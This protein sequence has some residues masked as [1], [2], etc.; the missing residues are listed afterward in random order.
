MVAA[1]SWL[2]AYEQPVDTE[3]Y[4]KVIDRPMTIRE[5]MDFYALFE[6]RYLPLPWPEFNRSA[7]EYF[8]RRVNLMRKSKP[9]YRVSD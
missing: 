8:R 7:A 3:L 2:L 5:R 6:K 4:F 9:F 1:N